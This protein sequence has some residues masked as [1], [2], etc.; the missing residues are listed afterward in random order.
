M[1]NHSSYSGCGWGR[2]GDHVFHFWQLHLLVS[3]SA[4]GSCVFGHL[5]VE[6]VS[7]SRTLPVTWAFALKGEGKERKRERERERELGMIRVGRYGGYGYGRCG[8]DGRDGGSGG[9]GGG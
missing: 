5:I 7:I 1:N 2:G 9:S 6:R 8:R 3:P 4:L